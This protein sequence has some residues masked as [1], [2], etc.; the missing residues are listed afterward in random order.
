MASGGVG[1]GRPSGSLKKNMAQPLPAAELDPPGGVTERYW[2][3]TFSTGAKWA[4]N[5]RK[6]VG[7]GL[8]RAT[9]EG[10]G[11]GACLHVKNFGG[12]RA[13]EVKTLKNRDQ[14]VFGCDVR[15]SGESDP[16]SS[17]KKFF[18]GVPSTPPCPVRTPLGN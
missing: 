4:R 5:G 11:R 14:S 17:P 1:G 13:S 18:G 12:P 9:V 15:A 2:L 10:R 3:W 7:V 16:P 8:A 6:W